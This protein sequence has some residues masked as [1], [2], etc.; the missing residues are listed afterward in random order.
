MRQPEEARPF[1]QAGERR[2]FMRVEGPAVIAWKLDSSVQIRQRACGLP[3]IANTPCGSCRRPSRLRAY[4]TH[5]RVGIIGRFEF[6]APVAAV[7]LEEL[8]HRERRRTRHPVAH[9][10]A[11]DRQTLRQ[12]HAR[13]KP[14][15]RAAGRRQ[16][17]RVITPAHRHRRKWREPLKLEVAQRHK[18]VAA[19]RAQE[20]MDGLGRENLAGAVGLIQVSAR[21]RISVR[22]VRSWTAAWAAGD[23]DWR[24][25]GSSSEEPPFIEPRGPVGSSSWACSDAA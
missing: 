14:A 23:R 17:G 25:A 7:V 12:R 24:Q 22:A 3:A 1:A 18:L 15:F 2:L 20:R 19:P 13:Q 21:Q 10:R 6:G 4:E 9:A 8:R 16:H 11:R 5:G